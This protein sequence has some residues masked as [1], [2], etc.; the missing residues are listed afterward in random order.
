MAAKRKTARKKTTPSGGSRPVDVVAAALEL[1]AQ[2]GWRHTTMADIAAAAGLPVVE[3]LGLYPSRGAILRELSR[4][5]DVAMTRAAEGEADTASVRERLFAMVMA[6][7]DALLPHRA[8]LLRIA[9]DALYDPCAPLAAS[10]ALRRSLDWMLEL[11]GVPATGLQGLLKRK[12][13]ALVYADVLRVWLRDDS[14]DM[15]KT[16]AALDKRLAQV[17]GLARRFSGFP[18]RS[19]DGQAGTA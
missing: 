4:R 6:R 3:L 17:E 1:A 19:L 12:A 15:A 5:A 11:A 10:R 7:F 14:A 2:Q 13:L 8:G 16:M 18:R 9:G